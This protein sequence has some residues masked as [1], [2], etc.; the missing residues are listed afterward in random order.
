M[1][2]VKKTWVVVPTEFNDFNLIF[3]VKIITIIA[4]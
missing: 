1:H 4:K 3:N 2:E